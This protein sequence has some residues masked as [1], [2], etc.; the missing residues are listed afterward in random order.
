MQIIV[1]SKG[2]HKV[3]VIFPLSQPFPWHLE[4]ACACAESFYFKDPSEH[5][6]SKSFL[7]GLPCCLSVSFSGLHVIYN[8]FSEFRGKS[9]PYFTGFNFFI[10]N[11]KT[12]V[13]F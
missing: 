12:V 5:Q 2:K 7:V 10:I 13:L 3:T 8:S 4:A 11:R 6:F 9:L 1:V